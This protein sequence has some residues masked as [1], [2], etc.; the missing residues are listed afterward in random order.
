MRRLQRC[1]PEIRLWQA[2]KAFR[3]WRNLFIAPGGRAGASSFVRVLHRWMKET[4]WA[5][6][7]A[8]ICA[9][10]SAMIEQCGRRWPHL[11]DDAFSGQARGENDAL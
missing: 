10:W 8:V 9:S 5:A 1:R 7:W 2:L 3:C 4:R 6:S 11:G